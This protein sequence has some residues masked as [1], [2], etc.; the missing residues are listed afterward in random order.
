MRALCVG[1]ACERSAA[2][3]S[4]TPF[5][6]LSREL[7][8]RLERGFYEGHS[9]DVMVVTGDTPV[10]GG[11]GQEGTARNTLWPSTSL[12]G[13]GTVPVVFAGTGVVPTADLPAGTGVDDISETLASIVSLRRPHP[14]VRTGRA[15][16]GV[17]SGATPRLLV[18]VVWKGVGSDQL[19]EERST[20]PVLADLMQT[21]AGTLDGQVGSLPLDAAATITTIGTG[22]LPFQ[23]GV[24]GTLMRWNRAAYTLQDKIVSS[25]VVRAW[26][27]ERFLGVIATLGDDLDRKF[28]GR[29]LIGLVGT[30]P[31][32]RGLI[33]RPWYVN[34]DRDWVTLVPDGASVR[35][36]L[37]GTLGLLESRPFGEDPVPDLL[38][39]VMSGRV[40]A[41]DAALRRLLD[42]AAAAS[43]D[44]V[45]IAVTATGGNEHISG[46]VSAA[47][48]R[49]RVE[50]AVDARLPVFEAAVPGGLY[51]DQKTI[52]R[53]RLSEDVVL[54]ELLRLRG[55]GGERLLV[56]AFPSS[57]VNF[58]RYC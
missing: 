48:L 1:H 11:D 51:L 57:A 56:D 55:P 15:I 42:A 5:C 14:G 27:P 39:V 21:G 9:P 32:D 24:T 46:G 19:R 22:G 7:R 53:L 37:R 26:H 6:S 20:W 25:P 18:E 38:G 54:Q 31:L 10:V 58:G 17:A 8:E 3:A 52:A 4:R 12:P 28:R 34:A 44:S 33:G 43:G 13:G 50:K 23:H 45:A 16:P 2:S 36:Q 40:A 35:D 49:R 41:L 29:P 30:D 47:S